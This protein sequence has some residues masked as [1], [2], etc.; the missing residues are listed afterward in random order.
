MYTAILFRISKYCINR[1]NSR[2][3]IYNLDI[4]I[5]LKLVSIK[6]DLDLRI[7]IHYIYKYYNRFQCLESVGFGI[8]NIG[9]DTCHTKD[10][11][12]LDFMIFFYIYSFTVRSKH[13]SEFLWILGA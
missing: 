7:S 6:L 1:L 5:Q 8:D 4:Y 9:K 3:I 10:I 2:K 12:T 13:I 11:K